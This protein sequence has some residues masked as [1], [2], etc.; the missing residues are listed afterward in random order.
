M[1]DQ[2][3]PKLQCVHIAHGSSSAC[4]DR[5]ALT[6][7]L[8]GCEAELDKQTKK[9]AD[10]RAQEPIGA[11]KDA[12]VLHSLT[13]EASFC[14][15][16]SVLVAAESCAKGE[17]CEA[18]AMPLGCRVL[19]EACSGRQHCDEVLQWQATDE[20]KSVDQGHVRLHAY[21]CGL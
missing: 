4:L 14:K 20:Q 18:D 12:E 19:E 2:L 3:C 21:R 11:P 15:N 7:K 9:R 10:A 5:L 8:Q 16:A 13:S 17:G 1:S 6:D